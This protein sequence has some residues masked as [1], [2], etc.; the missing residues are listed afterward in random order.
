MAPVDNGCI[1][2][3]FPSVNDQQTPESVAL[4][5]DKQAHKPEANKPDLQQFE[6][7]LL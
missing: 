2:W 4:M 1:K 6:D 5:L 3:P 7:A